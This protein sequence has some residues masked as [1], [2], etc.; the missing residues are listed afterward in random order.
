[1]KHKIIIA[2]TVVAIVFGSLIG[3]GFEMQKLVDTEKEAQQ[4]RLTDTINRSQ[5]RIDNL[6]SKQKEL[7]G[8][9]E[10]ARK[11]DIHD[12]GKLVQ[13]AQYTVMDGTAAV[14]GT[15]VRMTI[16]DKGADVQKGPLLDTKD[17]RKIINVL[18]SAGAEAI[19]VN[20]QRIVA[21]SAVV[22]SGEDRIMIN[23]VPI[24]KKGSFSYEILAI[25]HQDTL[26][27]NLKYEIVDLQESG[28]KVET[29]RQIVSIPSYK[30][31][32]QF[33]YAKPS[34]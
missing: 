25:G 21:T 5:Q 14:K 16:D 33:N 22:M 27:E 7:T 18:R 30:R 12:P 10:I 28:M 1:M 32:Y 8:Q 19:S 24:S 34:L 23:Q 26:L 4:G 29:V 15:G 17:L 3:I 9:L 6:K 31:G 11:E 13:M 2:I 20:G